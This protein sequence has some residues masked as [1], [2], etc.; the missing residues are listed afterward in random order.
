[1]NLMSRFSFSL[2]RFCPFLCQFVELWIID[3]FSQASLVSINQLSNI[4]F[5]LF[6]LFSPSNRPDRNEL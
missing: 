2:T 1:M 5:G 6:L 4:S 3:V